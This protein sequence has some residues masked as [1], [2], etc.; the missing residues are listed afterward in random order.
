MLQKA[1]STQRTFTAFTRAA[2]LPLSYR[3]SILPHLWCWAL[4]IIALFVICSETL[5]H[6]S[7]RYIASPVSWGLHIAPFGVKYFFVSCRVCTSPPLEMCIAPSCTDLYCLTYF[8]GFVYCPLWDCILLQF[9]QK[10]YIASV[11]TAF[12]SKL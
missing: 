3:E 9:V 5:L 7:Q 10:L 1:L 2:L 4:Y 12:L 8:T 6:F 11:C